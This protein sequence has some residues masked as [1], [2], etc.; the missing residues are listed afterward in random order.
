MN[1]SRKNDSLTVL[2]TVDG[3]TRPCV[4]YLNALEVVFKPSRIR[5]KWTL[6]CSQS[7]E[8][9]IECSHSESLG[10]MNA[11]INHTVSYRPIFSLSNETQTIWN[12]ETMPPVA[13]SSKLLGVPAML[14][15]SENL[16]QVSVKWRDPRCLFGN[17]VSWS[18]SIETDTKNVYSADIPFYCSRASKSDDEYGHSI[19]IK[20]STIECNRGEH[21]IVEKLELVSCKTYV[22]KLSPVIEM[23]N[24]SRLRLI[25]FNLIQNVSTNI[26]HYGK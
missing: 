21:L 10:Y 16:N 3:S 18:L 6:R 5:D 12:T 20:E 24:K 25:E 13:K 7:H 11:C 14:V 23:F 15:Q 1:I 22:I 19:Q 2:F 4:R 26:E 17:V 9:A 8:N